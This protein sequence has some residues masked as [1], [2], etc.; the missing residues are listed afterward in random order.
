[1]PETPSAQSATGPGRAWFLGAHLGD[2]TSC[3]EPDGWPE[4]EV[5][6][7]FYVSSDDPDVI[8]RE[9]QKVWH[10]LPDRLMEDTP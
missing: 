6:V 1:M 10:D 3:D 5:T 8:E 9:R 7:R 4:F 2:V